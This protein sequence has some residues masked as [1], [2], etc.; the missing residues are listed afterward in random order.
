MIFDIFFTK[1]QVP[2]Y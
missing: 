2:F 1:N